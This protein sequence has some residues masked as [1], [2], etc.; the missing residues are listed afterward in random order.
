MA[1]QD[2]FVR[3]D[4][5]TATAFDVL[6]VNPRVSP[7]AAIFSPGNKQTEKN[8]NKGRKLPPIRFPTFRYK[9]TFGW[10]KAVAGLASGGCSEV[11]KV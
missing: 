10:S 2:G 5:T 1:V 9:S 8:R 7:T 4:V 11:Q 3:C 6:A